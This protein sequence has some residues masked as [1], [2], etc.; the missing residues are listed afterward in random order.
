MDFKE[1]MQKISDAIKS[2]IKEDKTE[3]ALKLINGMLTIAESQFKTDL[4]NLLIRTGVRKDLN[5]WT[6]FSTK[7]IEEVEGLEID[8]WKNLVQLELD[9]EK[10][11]APLYLVKEYIESLADT[12]EYERLL[13]GLYLG[14]PVNSKI[15]QV[16]HCFLK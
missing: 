10:L 3:I 6:E 8:P 4:E 1:K 16:Y 11:E 12:E 2:N 15:V 9:G 5:L 7:F 13:I 14:S